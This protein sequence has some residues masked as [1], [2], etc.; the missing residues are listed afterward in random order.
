MRGSAVNNAIPSSPHPR[1][2]SPDLTSNTQPATG[3]VPKNGTGPNNGAV[4]LSTVEVAGLVYSS[5]ALPGI[6]RRRCGKGWCYIGPDK[7]HVRDPETLARI[8]SL[9]IPP[10]WTEV[11]ICPDPNGHIQATGRDAKGRKQYRYHPRWSE[12]RSSAKFGRV[13][14]FSHALPKIRAQVEHD[15][16]RQGLTREKVVATVVRL[17]ETT[18][19]RIGN[20]EYART[21]KSFG[22]TTLRDRHVDVSGTVVRFKFVGKSGQKHAVELHD[23]RMARIVKMCR[24]LPG[25]DL[26]QYVDD[27]GV[28]QQVDSG[29]VNAYLRSIAG[30]DFSAKDF[31][32]WGGTLLA[33]R[34]LRQ[35]TPPTS[36]RETKRTIN[37]VIQ[38][39]ASMLGNR[40]ATCRKYYVHPAILEAYADGSLFEA[41]ALVRDEGYEEA[42]HD[43]DLEEAALL[44]LLQRKQAQGYAADAQAPD[45][46]PD[47]CEDEAT[48]GIVDE[49]A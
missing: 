31:R 7:K 42:P 37:Q 13:I 36:Q 12:H 14:A 19:I 45:P 43:L 2:V 15:L 18:F 25:Y 8:R 39:V 26:F 46:I 1:K 34:E 47:E 33:A 3:A 32:T 30:A 49:D 20:K 23:R 48:D 4:P 24:D 10:A 11:W 40:P 17:L 9:A 28:R 22:L 16:R 35:M 44:E 29:D 41:V 38:R 21:N 6:G 5:D 27:E